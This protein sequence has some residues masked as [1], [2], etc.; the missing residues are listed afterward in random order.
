MLISFFND[1]PY[2]HLSHPL[3][4]YTDNKCNVDFFFEARSLFTQFSQK[5][6]SEYLDIDISEVIYSIE[7]YEITSI[8][9]F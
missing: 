6:V 2:A 8:Q 7:L 3:Y 4:V 5:G 9:T 1:E